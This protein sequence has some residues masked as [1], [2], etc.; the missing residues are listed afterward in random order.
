MIL[1][2]SDNSTAARYIAGKEIQ[3]NAM[4]PP[5][6]SARERRPAQ[7]FC[8][9]EPLERRSP[10]RRLQSPHQ[11]LHHLN[12]IR[13]VSYSLHRCANWLRRRYRVSCPQS[14]QTQCCPALAA[15]EKAGYRGPSSIFSPSSRARCT[16][17]NNSPATWRSAKRLRAGC[18]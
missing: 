16:L 9:A 8:R 2:K 7:I 14:P 13:T 4:L 15:V 18:Q 12:I 5:G 17:P 6:S 10:D 3:P 11:R 1:F